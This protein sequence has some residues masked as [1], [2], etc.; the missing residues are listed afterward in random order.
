MSTKCIQNTLFSSM[1]ENFV[2]V[3]DAKPEEIEKIHIREKTAYETLQNGPYYTRN[4]Y[5][6]MKMMK[7][8]R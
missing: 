4:K 5:D 7:D 1:N 8:E 6:A 2:V 3:I